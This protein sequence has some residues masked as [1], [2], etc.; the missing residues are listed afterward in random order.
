MDA[1]PLVSAVVQ[2]RPR[3]EEE[4]GG[5]AEGDAGVATQAA[6]V[7]QGG[8]APPS[9]ALSARGRAPADVPVPDEGTAVSRTKAYFTKAGFEVHA[10]V[11]LTFSI[12][13]PQSLF[14]EFFGQ[15]L[16][17]DDE[18]FGSPVTTADGADE[19]S[20]ERLP[21]QVRDMVERVFFPPPPDLP[22]DI[23]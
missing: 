22:F 20:L 23:V 18:R 12:A 14:E 17:V 7:L 1:D 3:T 10:P 4:P 13:A 8:G 6:A 16:A 21:G 11:G 2:L 15:G 19:L 5:P 9:P